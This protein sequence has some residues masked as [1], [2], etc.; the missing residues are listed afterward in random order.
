MLQL[1]NYQLSMIDAIRAELR[2]GKDRILAVLATGGGKTAL[3]AH[4][5]ANATAKGKRCWFA[6]HRREL[7]KQSIETLEESAGVN[8]GVIAAG[9]G[10]NGYHLAQVASIQTL[11][12]RWEKY[13]LPDLIICD[14]SHH[15]VSPSWSALLK[16]LIARK[17]DLKLIGLTATPRR[18]DGRGLGEWFQVIVE[19]PSTASL[20]QDGYLAKYRMWGA[21]LPDLTGVHS[22][23]GDY[24]RGELEAA[25]SRTAVVGDALAEYKKHC[26]GKRA[27]VFMWSIRASQELAQR[28]NDAGISARHVDGETDSAARDRAMADFRAGR[29]K[30]LSN[31]DLFGEGLDVPSVEA[32]FF[33][34]PTQS[35]SMALQQYGRIL[36]P[37][38]GK[39]A[40]LLFDHAGHGVS[41]GFPDDPREW[42]LDGNETKPK[43]P[44]KV[45]VRQCQKCYATVSLST[46]ICKWCGTV[47]EIKPRKVELAEGELKELSEEQRAVMAEK[48]AARIEQGTAATLEQ[49]LQVQRRRGYREGWAQH[50]LEARSKPKHHAA[51]IKAE[52]VPTI[53]EMSNQGISSHQIA[54]ELEISQ[55]RVSTIIND[56]N[57]KD[58]AAAR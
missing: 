1:R 7:L 28:F 23:G 42:T 31:V 56:A 53:L 10:A 27:L 19:G 33:M 20:I 38:E 41:H 54:R 15:L 9:F 51:K 24:N 57:Y 22:T 17:P 58:R 49:L 2:A 30:V 43:K 32:G 8:C 29:V 48:R 46:K 44:Q 47:F 52:E 39:D 45:P 14:E 50:V 16:K 11:I 36:R 26:D 21:S 4:M 18:L 25:L 55:S 6:V 12:R 5:I 3:S 34:R 40:A 37:F 13:P 35:L